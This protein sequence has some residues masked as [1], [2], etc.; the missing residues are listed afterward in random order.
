MAWQSKAETARGVP[1]SW[2]LGLAL[3]IILACCGSSTALAAPNDETN[4]TRLD[5]TVR[6][7]QNA[8]NGD[9]GFTTNGDAGE[10][11]DPTFTAWAAIALATA[12]INPQDQ[13]RPGGESAYTYLADHVGALALTTEFERVLLVVDA[14]GTSPEDFGGDD[15]VAA[16]LHRQLPEGGFYHREDDPTPG[17]N[18]TIFA[19]LALSPI[20][21]PAVEQAIA[22]ALE[23]LERAQNS[24]GSWPSTSTCPKTEQAC[25]PEEDV[26]MT[27]AA[28][29]ALNAA[30]AHDTQAQQKAIKYLH[31]AQNAD[32]GFPE[33]PSGTGPESET[34]A[35][36]WAVQG[37]WAAGEN[38]ENWAAPSSGREPLHFLESMQ[39]E[40]GSVQ[41]K[42]SSDA[43]PVFMTA[44]AA[45][46]FAGQPLPPPLVP[47]TVPTKSPPQ[48]GG[49]IAGGGG[50]GAPLFIR[51]QPQSKG[52][53]RGG[54][55]QLKRGRA[56]AA[57]KLTPRNG[58]V[59]LGRGPAA[60]GA[61][62]G[63]SGHG[64]GSAATG[65]GD[66]LSGVGTSAGNGQTDGEAVK[67][68]LIS[69]PSTARE[70][71]LE[72]GA[73]GLRGAGTGGG[74]TP[75]LAIAIGG[76]IALLILTG[77]QL[78]RRRP[79]VIL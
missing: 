40:D 68:I 25:S 30:G 14:A 38:P 73:P 76:L 46:A 62:T 19:I 63:T 72:P 1:R 74:E 43:N 24:D 78:E 34:S 37:I 20:H 22:S 27:G 33:N 3:G 18:D 55:R 29:E 69:A 11:S 64:S 47:R 71:A 23:W 8:Q 61:T 10:S 66:A 13:A 45:P 60:T 2:A 65:V 16:I 67:G 53:T 12:G 26:G 56:I 50:D 70:H 5:N 58:A 28:I 51:P 75:W 79:Q 77:T 48:G 57:H 35:T 32:G 7:L 6:F 41:W 42:A 17:V 36:A 59:K 52:R 54:V 31:R 4:R 39:H 21:E 9:G 49:V 15:L 44:Y